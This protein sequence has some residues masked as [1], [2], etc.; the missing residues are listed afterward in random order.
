MVTLIERVYASAASAGF[1]KTCVWQPLDGSAVQTH[2]VGWVA[3]DQDVLSGLTSST[4]YVMTYPNT[5]FTG[6]A[7]RDSVQI[8]GVAYQVREVQAVG[9]GSELRAKLMRV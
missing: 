9:D 1:L 2:S 7:S 3:A 6:L 5:A 4:E 8:G